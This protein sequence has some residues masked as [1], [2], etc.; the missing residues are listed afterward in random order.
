W[1]CQCRND[2]KGVSVLGETAGTILGTAAEGG[3]KKRAGPRRRGRERPGRCSSPARERLDSLS[4]RAS[5]PRPIAESAWSHSAVRTCARD[6]WFL[7]GRKT[8]PPARPETCAVRSCRS[9]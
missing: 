2:A 4:A 9:R 6:E 8:K 7:S 1:P 3:A 5:D